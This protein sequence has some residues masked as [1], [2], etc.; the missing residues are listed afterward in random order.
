MPRTFSSRQEE[1]RAL[2]SSLPAIDL[3]ATILSFG[4]RNMRAQRTAQIGR[5]FADCLC[6]RNPAI[7]LSIDEMDNFA[8]LIKSRSLVHSFVGIRRMF[9]PI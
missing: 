4:K 5:K 6:N 2:H 9:M 8:D 3:P 7:A 1:P